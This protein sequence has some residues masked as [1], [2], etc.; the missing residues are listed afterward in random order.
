MPQTVDN[1][2]A[3]IKSDLGAAVSAGTW[4]RGATDPHTP[5]SCGVDGGTNIGDLTNT[6]LTQ[7][8]TFAVKSKWQ[9]EGGNTGSGGLKIKG[10]EMV[11]SV[12]GLEPS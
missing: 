10:A 7:V 6:Q 12:T 9:S 11:K 3:E 5:A 4:T 1:L 8:V 2:I